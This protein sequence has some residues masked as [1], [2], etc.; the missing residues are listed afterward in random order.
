MDEENLKKKEPLLADCNEKIVKGKF[1]P[2][3]TNLE[4]DSDWSYNK[5]G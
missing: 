1:W 3:E 2:G 4:T 5:M